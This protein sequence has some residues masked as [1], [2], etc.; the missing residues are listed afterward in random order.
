MKGREGHD[1]ARDDLI[2]ELLRRTGALVGKNEGQREGSV[3]ARVI[4]ASTS[5]SGISVLEQQISRLLSLA[6]RNRPHPTIF[7]FSKKLFRN[8]FRKL[9]C[10]L[11]VKMPKCAPVVCFLRR[12][13]V[14]LIEFSET[15]LVIESE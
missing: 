11:C 4:S 9:F 5:N 1:T 10:A 7:L 8:K 15:L 12:I 3:Q 14:I 2:Q 6:S 13:F